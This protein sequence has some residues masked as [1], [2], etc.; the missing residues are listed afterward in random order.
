MAVIL[1]AQVIPASES[2]PPTFLAVDNASDVMYIIRGPFV[3][4]SRAATTIA[5][6]HFVNDSVVGHIFH[7]TSA[8]GCRVSFIGSGSGGQ[9][10]VQIGAD[11]TDPDR[12]ILTG[13]GNLCKW[14]T[15]H[16][17]GVLTNNGSGNLTW[18]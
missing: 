9:A 2:D 5:Q 18:V 16:G 12:L 3:F 4:D 13:N 1:P 8:N 6:T 17:S 14:P 7:N 11:T 10:N 15:S